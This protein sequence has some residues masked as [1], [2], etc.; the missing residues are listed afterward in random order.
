VTSFLLAVFVVAASLAGAWVL[1]TRIYRRFFRYDVRRDHFFDFPVSS[2]NLLLSAEGFS[3]PGESGMADTA[4]VELRIDATLAGR[5]SEPWI[6]MRT[7]DLCAHH[8]FERSARGTRYLNLSALLTEPPQPGQKIF[9]RGFGLAWQE[10]SA[11]LFCFRNDW[12]A[13]PRSVVIA[14][15]PDDAE[16]AAFGL[17]R[18]SDSTVV[19]VTAGDRGTFYCGKFPAGDPRAAELTARVRAWD[20]ITAPMVGGAGPERAINLGY[21]DSTL[22]DAFA[23]PK[24]PINAPGI[25]RSAAD[26]RRLNLSP[27]IENADVAQTWCSLVGDLV[28]VFSKTNPE[29]IATPHPLLD[30]HPDHAFST[31][32][33]C[34]ALEKLG[35][36]D[37]SLLLYTNHTPWSNLHPVG[38]TDGAISLPPH[39]G[40]PLPFRSIKSLPLSDDDMR[41]KLLAIEAHHDLRALPGAAPG[42]T[43][44]IRGFAGGLRDC[45]T[46]LDRHATSY[47]R[48]AVRPNELFFVVP[49]SDAPALREA[50]LEKWRAGKIEWHR[51]K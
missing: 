49:F 37:G 11:R 32:A 39:F 4:I 24:Q 34:E 26:I 28:R 5:W 31:V 9:L 36:R 13:R 51:S 16:I 29:L 30:D 15:H 43:G 6:E 20:S 44:V 14:P 42:V 3:W 2:V 23:N 7:H 19:T 22:A 46:G 25:H 33:V 41:L 45:I 18:N 27:L 17:Y 47:F 8:Y 1:R 50:F 12:P 35:S 10:Q 21:I 48:R 40:E 38:R